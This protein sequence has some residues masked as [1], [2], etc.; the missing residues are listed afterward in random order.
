MLTNFLLGRVFIS[1]KNWLIK[2]V[3][4]FR[5]TN[6]SLCVQS[7]KDTKTKGSSLV[8]RSCSKT[9]K[10]LWYQSDKNEL[11]LDQLLCLQASK[12]TPILYKCHEMGAD[13]EWKHKGGVKYNSFFIF[14]S[15]I[16][17]SARRNFDRDLFILY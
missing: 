14:V 7:A 8:L 13:Q 11:V 12:P 1:Q 5:L 10:Q 15:V 4:I 17:S 6:S 9:K 3:N 2:S 16:V